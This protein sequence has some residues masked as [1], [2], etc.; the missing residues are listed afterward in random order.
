MGKLSLLVK[1][2]CNG[3]SKLLTGSSTGEDACFLLAWNLLLSLTCEIN[4]S[5][6]EDK[7]GKITM[8]KPNHHQ[9]FGNPTA[10]SSFKIRVKLD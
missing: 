5:R 4:R 7:I 6:L 1:N 10:I 9:Y 3:A 2:I 8:H